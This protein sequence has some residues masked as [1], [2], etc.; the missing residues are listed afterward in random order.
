MAQALGGVEPVSTRTGAALR[1]Y[2]ADLLRGVPSFTRSL[3]RH[4]LENRGETASRVIRRPVRPQRA[5]Q[6]PS[7]GRRYAG[8]SCRRPIPLCVALVFVLLACE[9]SVQDADDP[10]IRA[11]RPEG[12]ES[13][14]S[15]S[16]VRLYYQFV[17]ARG[18][19]RFVE[20]LEDVPESWRANVG[21]VK[22]D[23][24]PP[25]SPAQA[26][27]SRR[28]RLAKSGGVTIAKASAGSNIILYSAEWCG[29]CR[30]AKRYLGRQGVD[31][32]LRD[33]D[34]PAAAR[35]LQAKTGRRAIP[36]LEVGG[37]IVTGFSAKAYDALLDKA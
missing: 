36:V 22:M 10:P 35:E 5:L 7:V 20:R 28:Q 34:N 1:R 23:G 27:E 6:E 30:K 8:M 14:E 26:A 32:E 21:F 29:A 33:I 2:A 19:V 4:L 12:W 11:E 31:F 17:D 18:N 15:G 24:P 37:R 9:G 3:L 16:A 25:L 13:L